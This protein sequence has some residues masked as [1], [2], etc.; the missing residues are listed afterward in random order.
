MLPRTYMQTRYGDPPQV[1][2]GS[3]VKL[4][5]KSEGRNRRNTLV[6]NYSKDKNKKKTKKN[7]KK[8]KKNEKRKNKNK[9]V[10]STYWTSLAKESRARRFKV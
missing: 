5:T 7:K 10:E 4:Q 2:R 9:G 1:K 3:N 8:N 6:Y